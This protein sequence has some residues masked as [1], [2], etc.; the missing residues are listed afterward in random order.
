[1]SSDEIE[2]IETNFNHDAEIIVT[3]VD[4]LTESQKSQTTP[5]PEKKTSEGES[6]VKCDNSAGSGNQ[7][8]K[9]PL[10]SEEAL[11]SEMD[12][13]SSDASSDKQLLN[14]MDSRNGNSEGNKVPGQIT[15]PSSKIF[16]EGKN[17]DIE[18]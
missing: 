6:P 3:Q 5:E 4:H 15:L 18:F 8:I 10:A 2:T 1:M 12:V 16:P 9:A 7:R 14:D 11:E 17:N 13:V